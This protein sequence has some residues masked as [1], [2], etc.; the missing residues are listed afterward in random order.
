MGKQNTRQRAGAPRSRQRGAHAALHYRRVTNKGVPKSDHGLRASTTLTVRNDEGSTKAESVLTG[1]CPPEAGGHAAVPADVLP[2]LATAPAHQFVRSLLTRGP[3]RNIQTVPAGEA[4]GGRGLSDLQRR[5][6]GASLR[7][8]WQRA[9]WHTVVST[10]GRDSGRCE[11]AEFHAR[12]LP[13]GIG[14][15]RSGP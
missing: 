1:P 13:R 4:L 3:H 12:R 8:P 5:Q 14:L 6:K 10:I 11:P 15:A 2:G 7:T 9:G